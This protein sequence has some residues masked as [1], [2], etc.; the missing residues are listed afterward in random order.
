V[1][2]TVNGEQGVLLRGGP[3][4]E[5]DPASGVRFVQV[6]GGTFTMGSGDEEKD[7]DDDEKPA[8]QVTLSSF[9]IAKTEITNAQYRTFKKDRNYS[10]TVIRVCHGAGSCFW[11]QVEGIGGWR[12][13]KEAVPA[14]VAAVARQRR[15]LAK[16]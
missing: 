4:E 9:E 15:P 5:T 2:K 12:R 3:V 10:D 14:A 13:S 11:K 7:A 6:C 16:R 1:V 8:H